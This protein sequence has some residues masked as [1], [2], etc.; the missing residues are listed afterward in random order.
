MHLEINDRQPERLALRFRSKTNFIVVH[1]FGS[2]QIGYTE[3][4]MEEF[5]LRDPTGVASVT[6]GGSWSSKKK[7]IEAWKND[8]IPKANQRRAKVPYTFSI[9][10]HGIVTQWLPLLAVGAHASEVN[11]NS[12]SVAVLYDVFN[13]E[14]EPNEDQ[15]SALEDLLTY[16]TQVFPNAKVVG[17]DDVR[18]KPKGC[19]GFDLKPTKS[20]ALALKERLENGNG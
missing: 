14:A 20:R 6:L 16:L 4:E 12:V 10:S 19:P 7:K 5:F 11:I 15:M 8:G 2:D 1:G 13:D 9:D 3:D 17:H 18:S